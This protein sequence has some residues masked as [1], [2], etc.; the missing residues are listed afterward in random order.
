MHPVAVIGSTHNLSKTSTRMQSSRFH[1]FQRSNAT[2]VH[3]RVACFIYFILA[4]RSRHQRH[5]RRMRYIDYML[6]DQIKRRRLFHRL[7]KYTYIQQQQKVCARE[8]TSQFKHQNIICDRRHQK[9]KCFGRQQY[10]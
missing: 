10:M 8:A 4:E 6:D 5:T 1:T 7:T 9:T 2:N 3:L